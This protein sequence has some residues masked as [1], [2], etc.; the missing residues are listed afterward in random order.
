[1]R[2]LI[3]SFLAGLLLVPGAVAQPFF[4]SEPTPLTT[5][6]YVPYGGA[7]RL[8]TNGVL[9]YLLWS[10]DGKVRITPITNV[11]RVGRPV[12][13][14][15]LADAVWTGSHFLVV[16][17][18]APSTY[19]GRLVS[20][21]GGSIGE[22]FTVV[23][24]GAAGEPRLAFDGGRVLLLYGTAP[25]HAVAL[26]RDGVPLEQPRVAPVDIEQSLDV[27]ATARTAEFLVTLAGRNRV[28]QVAVR[29]GF[30]SGELHTAP[31]VER[32]RMATAASAADQL[33]LWTNS[34]GLMQARHTPVDGRPGDIADYTLTETL[35]A[36]EVDVTY[37]GRDYI[38]AYRINSRLYIRY[39]NAALPFSIV[40]VAPDSAVSLVSVNGRTYA[41]WHGRG[42]N[43]SIAVRDVLTLVGDTGAYGAA[44]QALQASA[45]SATSALFTWTE[46]T[47]LYAGI[48]TA[49]GN[50]YERQLPHQDE[51]APLAASD[52]AGF[53]VIH[54]TPHQGWT[55]TFLDAQGNFAGIGPRVQFYPTGIAWTGDAYV[56]VGL[57]K[58][59]NLVAS[60]LS[61]A[62]T[63]TTPVLL[64]LPRPGRKIE[65]GRVAA[66]NGE[67]LVLWMDYELL[68]C[69]QPCNGYDSD[70]LA[71]RVNPATLQRIDAQS[72]LVAEDAIHPDAVWDGVRYVI[73]WKD[74]LTGT[75]EWRTLR[76]NGAGSGISTVTGAVSFMPRLT[77]VPGGV[78]I[79]ADHGDVVF[80][81]EGVETVRKLGTNDVHAVA[82]V[83][84]RVAYMQALARD[85][86]PYHGAARLNVRIGD[87]V[88]PGPKP[89]APQITRADLPA[90]ANAIT[91]EWTA[92]AGAVNGYR[93]EYRVDDGAWNE[94]DV[95]FDART[96]RLVIPPWRTDTVRYQF[97]VRAVNDAGFSDYSAPVTVRTRKI[98]AVR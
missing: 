24:N 16:G 40:D 4:F 50:W 75:L 9:P 97:R 90:S 54:A 12:L 84:S 96:Q 49:S 64:A 71:A 31:T 19:V 77:L 76:T 81:R 70:V 11:R 6:R 83:G 59:Q 44:T 78:A 80:L 88:P 37:D 95:W 85:E 63:A 34:D 14:A 21:N 92:P 28:A 98:R 7:P 91:V 66:R 79:T 56:V 30:W 33:T 55:S 22:P 62:G 69:P 13:D 74:Y 36:Q 86:M 39:F 46:G 94:L 20:G 8:V 68:V 3:W 42:G 41:A 73:A 23:P 65:H 43:G 87:L 2:Q 53:V 45:S 17:F 35:G 51:Q 15:H 48:R 72:L 89:S 29:K 38:Y 93:V 52:G 61:L 18:Q 58:D 47:E 67:L 57:D 5:T 1:M 10:S 25:V 82:T 27:D 60:R 26:S 32:R